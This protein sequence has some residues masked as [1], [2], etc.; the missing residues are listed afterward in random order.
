MGKV[1]GPTGASHTVADLIAKYEA[2]G[3]QP[4]AL[5]GA[6]QKAVS[7]SLE[8]SGHDRGGA[9]TKATSQGPTLPNTQEKVHFLK[10]AED[11]AKVNPP[12]MPMDLGTVTTLEATLL[13]EDPKLTTRGAAAR[14]FDSM[15]GTARLGHTTNGEEIF[16]VLEN[17]TRSELTIIESDFEKISNGLTL[18]V[19]LEKSLGGIDL[20]KAKLFLMGES[21][22]ADIRDATLLHMAM[23]G[24]G[25]DEKGVLDALYGK[26]PEEISK[27]SHQ[28]RIVAGRDLGSDI[29]NEHSGKQKVY[30]QAVYSRGRI[31]PADSIKAAMSGWITDADMVKS[32]L[33]DLG[34]A[35]RFQELKDLEVSYKS[36]YGTELVDDLRENLSTRNY[37]E[38]KALLENGTLQPEDEIK[39]AMMG[40]GWLSFGFMGFGTDP[41]KIE[42]QFAGKSKAERAVIV[43]RFNQKYGDLDDA[44][45]RNLSSGAF[46]DLKIILAPDNENGRLSPAQEFH[47][48]MRGLG[49]DFGRA[50]E[51]LEGLNDDERIE[52]RKEYKELFKSDIEYDI[53]HEFWGQRGDKLKRILDKGE[54]NVADRI[55]YATHGFR[56]R[57]DGGE[58]IAA[59]EAA[60]P[61][62]RATLAQDYSKQWGGELSEVLAGRTLSSSAKLEIQL[63]LEHGELS[64]GDKIKCALEGFGVHRRKIYDALDA[65][66]PKE[67]QAICEDP[68]LMERIRSRMNS[69]IGSKKPLERVLSHIENGGMTLGDK[70][71]YACDSL[72]TSEDYILSLL[73]DLDFESRAGVIQEYQSARGVNLVDELKKNMKR[74][75]FFKA[76]DA[77]MPKPVSVR[78]RIDQLEYKVSRERGSGSVR[79]KVSDQIVDVF[80]H[81]GV[82]LD[83]Q[84]REF[85]RLPRLAYNA[86]GKPALK[87]VEAEMDVAAR[88]VE[89]ATGDYVEAK[90]NIANKISTVATL[91]AAATSVAA[92]GGLSAPAALAIIAAAT[93]ATKAASRMLVQGD[94]YH[95]VGYDGAY[96]LGTGAAEGAAMFAIGALGNELTAFVGSNVLASEGVDVSTQGLTAI[97][98]EALGSAGATASQA[99]IDEAA[100]EV[101]LKKGAEYMGQ[102]FAHQFGMGVAMGAA[103][104][105]TYSAVTGVSATLLDDSLWERDLPSAIKKLLSETVESAGGGAHGWTIG[106]AAWNIGAVAAESTLLQLRLGIGQGIAARENISFSDNEMLSAGKDILGSEASGLSSDAIR[107]AGRDKLVNDL[108]ADYLKNTVQGRVLASTVN[109]TVTRGVA[110]YPKTLLNSLGDHDTWQ[111]G[112]GAG[113]TNVSEDAT[114]AG[115][116]DAV[117]RAG[118]EIAGDSANDVGMDGARATAAKNI[119]WRGLAATH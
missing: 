31:E 86:G 95:L 88:C 87:A 110:A 67:L 32:T 68:E 7:D 36:Y 17:R 5:A 93:G 74:R 91:S 48:T 103:K 34:E 16:R 51:I 40:R 82:I 23:D 119:V 49:A 19:A 98:Q 12:P 14:L 70:L 80:S 83:H 4:S 61:E 109:N 99:A 77:L 97:G 8:V 44:L 73:A 29:E 18:P 60:T 57:S 22:E 56:L 1:V 11:A 28:Y 59:L 76:E 89:R 62:E 66:S 20:R 72:R 9:S 6:S 102:S 111:Y 63:R 104:G 50:K 118:G 117:A 114:R 81:K 85:K 115:V 55:Y 13:G 10:P 92:T 33:R 113:L 21:A 24:V 112:V 15:G 79:S 100:R 46:A 3:K 78:D 94:S 96:D 43:E 38:A 65:A 41:K 26:T 42:E 108:G 90:D 64:A 105:L 107:L 75:E 84:V 27:I 25:T 54:L 106:T 2:L 69:W 101:L 53:G 47:R 71:Y 52:L 58:I 116:N 45:Y 30:A 37:V 35:G 39:L